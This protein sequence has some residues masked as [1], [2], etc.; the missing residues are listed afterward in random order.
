MET[1][2]YFLVLVF[3]NVHIYNIP[4]IARY[5]N[6]IYHK[7]NHICVMCENKECT[8]DIRKTNKSSVPTAQ[9]N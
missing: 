3:K 1:S 7:Y 2:L 4:C 5:I 6:H 9:R 8:N